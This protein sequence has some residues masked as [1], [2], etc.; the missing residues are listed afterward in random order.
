MYRIPPHLTA[1]AAVALAA[2]IGAACG[3]DD[4]DTAAMST[5]AC[6][7]YATIGASMFGDPSAVPEAAA[8]L[9]AEAPEELHESAVTY[10]NTFVAA[11]DGDEA[12]LESP[13]FV[14]AAEELGAAA[15]ET[16]ESAAQLDVEGIDYGFEGLPEEVD[17]GR[18]AIRFTNATSADEQHELVLM[19]KADGVTQTAAE[20][21]ELPEE[22]LMSAAVPVAVVF[23]DEKGGESVSLVDLEPGSYVAICMIPTGGDGAPHAMNGMIADLE[24]VG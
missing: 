6:D 19:K 1:L 8:T 24:V 4:N 23:A 18:L 17:S 15:Y 11:F 2:T 7:A 5:A 3:S 10:G 9:A 20:L 12:A 22:E 13:E 21:L 14:A 16:C